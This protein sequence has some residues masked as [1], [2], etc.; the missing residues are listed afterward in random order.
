MNFLKQRIIL[1]PKT[2]LTNTEMGHIVLCSDKN[3]LRALGV[4]VVSVLE[5]T[6]IPC[7][8]HIFYNGIMEEAD[9]QKFN[10]LARQYDISISIYY[11]DNMAVSE[12]PHN[13][14]ISVTAY[15]RLLVPYILK[16]FDVNTC[17]YLDTDILIFHD[18]RELFS[19]DL[20]AHAAYVIKDAISNTSHW[21]D[22]CKQIGM[23]G[24][25]Y[26]NS[27]VMVLNNDV[28]VR[29]DLGM[30]A[31]QL[32]S[33]HHFTYMD[34]DVLNVILEGNVIFDAA[35]M[36]NCTMGVTNQEYHLLGEEQIK[37]VHFT[38]TK[39]PWKKFTRYW[40]DKNPRDLT[41]SWAF[42]YYKKWRQYAAK[43]PWADVPFEEPETYSEW[44]YLSAMYRRNGEY[45]KAISAYCIYINKKIK[46]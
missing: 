26:F 32:A 5:H 17:L 29:D 9:K 4:T 31:I 46:T 38:G 13:E 39:K 35:P 20:Q 25:S 22:Y 37:I 24:H 2:N 6:C 19:I 10:T 45:G 36:Y 15:Y 28:M 11:L 42:S 23:K 1:N 40:G 43:S 14:A 27:G 3:V 33:A 30:K 16:T 34:Q 18:M 21:N 8:I 12:L 7:H 41:H 44:R